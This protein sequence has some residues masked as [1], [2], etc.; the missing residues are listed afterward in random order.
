MG[1]LSMEIKGK[2]GYKKKERINQGRV[3]LTLL[4]SYLE[5]VSS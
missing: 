2:L 4:P 5:Q 3:S 1:V